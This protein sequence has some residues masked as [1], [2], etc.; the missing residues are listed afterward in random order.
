MMI[1]NQ[2]I[3]K[4][5]VLVLLVSLIKNI[6]YKKLNTIRPEIETEDLL[7]AITKNSETLIEQ[8][9]RKAVGILEFRMTKPGEKFHFNPLI[10]IK[11]DWMIGLTFLEVYNSIFNITGKNNKSEVFYFPD[12]RTGGISYQKV[13]SVIEKI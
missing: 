9:H 4:V 13:G 8:T 3:L 11:G 6:K 2:L 12:P 5:K 10:E 1:T 7:L